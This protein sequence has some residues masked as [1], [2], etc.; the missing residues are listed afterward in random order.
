MLR[1]R[2]AADPLPLA[3]V[4]KGGG[5]TMLAAAELV[6]GL[7]IVGLTLQDVFETVV[8][9]GESQTTVQIARRLTVLSLLV[10]RRLRSG[11]A[12]IP[13][14]F[15]PFILLASFV[16]W[17]LLLILGFGCIAHALA[18][19][20][21]P[22]L[23]SF[24]QALFIAGSSLVTIGLSETD[25]T[26]PA[27][28]MTVAAGFCG[29]AVMTMAVTYLLEVQGSIAQSDAGI[30]KLMTSSGEPPSALGLLE[31][32]AELGCESELSRVLLNGRN[33]CAAVL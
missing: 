29:L 21:E 19:W 22:P 23:P 16:S 25:A 31:R 27:R 18:E 1:A 8:V 33:W 15:A 6:L 30:L 9:P 3:A 2:L 7:I 14:G 4:C 11:R 12:P 13:T 17:M 26:G 32:Y 24:S 5:G 28:W 10:L 20:F